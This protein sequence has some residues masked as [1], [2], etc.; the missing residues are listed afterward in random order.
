[1]NHKKKKKIRLKT[2]HT[3]Q[4]K[5]ATCQNVHIRLGLERTNLE[6]ELKNL[7]PKKSDRMGRQKIKRA[8]GKMYILTNAKRDKKKRACKMILAQNNDRLNIDG[9]C[10][11]YSRCRM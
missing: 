11:C 1:M 3:Y 8:S 10:I 6:N 7:N 4:V 2:L 5:A 9:Y